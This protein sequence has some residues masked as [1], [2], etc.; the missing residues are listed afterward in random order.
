MRPSKRPEETHT[1]RE[2][3]RRDQTVEAMEPVGRRERE[4]SGRRVEC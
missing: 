3:E 2:N 4:T 1:Y